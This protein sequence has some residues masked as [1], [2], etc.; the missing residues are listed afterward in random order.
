VQD[1]AVF[2]G[3]DLFAGEHG[4]A[5]LRDAVEGEEVEHGGA[6]FV[7]QFGF[8]VVE[9]EVVQ[10]GGEVQEAVGVL[11]EQVADVGDEAVAAA[12]G[13]VEKVVSIQGQNSGV[14]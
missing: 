8:G 12:N 10:A 9:Q 6:R 11:G 13:E 14:F 4:I 2:G 3:V 1:G 7:R 5:G